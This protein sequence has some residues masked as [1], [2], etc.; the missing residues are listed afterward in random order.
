[1]DVDKAGCPAFIWRAAAENEPVSIT[2]T[3]VC[4]SSIGP[5]PSVSTVEPVI[6]TPRLV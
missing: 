6:G 2:L 5:F 3:N 1:M 4:T